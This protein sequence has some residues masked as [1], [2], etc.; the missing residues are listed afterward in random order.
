VTD[1]LSSFGETDANGYAHLFGETMVRPVAQAAVHAP[2][3][4]A[5]PDPDD[6]QESDTRT[7]TSTDTAAG[8]HDG[9]TV[10]T[11]DIAALRAGRARGVAPAPAVDAAP[12]VVLELSTGQRE[13]LDQPILLGRS[14][15]VSQVSGVRMPRLVTVGDVDQDISRNHAQFTLEGD[16]VVVTDL[17]SRNGTLIRLPGKEQQKLRAGEPTAILVGTVVD[18]GSGI[19]LTVGE[20]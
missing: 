8:D 6:E 16:T 2:D 11:S 17:H 15:S 12:A 20:A 4:D 1:A 13:L 18:F 10:M 14:P 5:A 9:H 7:D 3:P 19:T